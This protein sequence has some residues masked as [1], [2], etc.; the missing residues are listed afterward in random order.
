MQKTDCFVIIGFGSL[1]WDLDV[2]ES[3]VTGGWHYYS[4]PNL[5]LEFS[6]ISKKRQQALALVIDCEWGVECPTSVIISK[7]AHVSEV[8]FDLAKREQTLAENIG[9]CQRDSE[10][11]RSRSKF[12]VGC[13]KNWLAG[14]QW[15][16]AVWTDSPSNFK[17]KTQV[18]FSVPA[19]LEYLQS[20]PNSSLIEAKRYIENA[21]DRVDTPLRRALA[22]DS[23]WKSVD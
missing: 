4:G 2:L 16:G 15:V 21:P 11:V 14:T 9:F 19:A 17:E 6:L 23:W 12:V 18:G 1:I 5:P 8:V 7:R 10:L 22:A 20:L 13:V 3:H